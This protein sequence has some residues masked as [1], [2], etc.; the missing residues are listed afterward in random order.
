MQ[1]QIEYLYGLDSTNIRLGLGPISRLLDRLN[2]PH[3]SYATVLIGG[4]N[5]KGSI[6]AMVASILKLSGHRV[7]LYTSP[8]LIDIRERIKVND[9]MITHEEMASCIDRIR[10]RLVE[11]ITYF[12]FLTAI[13]FL[14]FHRSGVDMAVLEVGMGGR[15]DATNVVNPL[16]SVISNVS[17][18]HRSYL[19]NSLE[20]IAFEKGGIIKKNGVC[21]TAAKQSRVIRI[22]EEIC[23]EKHAAF[24]RLGKEFN[25]EVRQDGTFSYKDVGRKYKHL[26]CS[27]KGR[28]QIENAALAIRA[29]ESMRLQGV[30]ID[31]EAISRGIRN[32]QWEGRLEILQHHPTILIDGAHNPAGI[33]SL[34]RALKTEFVYECLILIFAVLD[35]KDCRNMLR[36]IIPFVDHLIITKPQTDRAILPANILTMASQYPVRQ[37][38]II[39]SSIDALQ[40]A[41][42]LAGM[43]DLICVAGS[44]YLVGE[45]KK[46]F[47]QQADEGILATDILTGVH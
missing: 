7:G 40:Y 14:H 31:D 16:V 15:L 41:V 6:A 11:D 13:A 38:E 17:L 21:I 46:A 42:A 2:T 33:S 3:M 44:L 1:D 25:V 30:A 35:D 36:K 5:G 47:Q 24:L 8:H 10:E 9:R 32:T 20:K 26:V 4:T 28:H 18:D 37:I 39:E 29:I 23:F 22:L 43:N 27:L 19:G 34:C 45:I 12:E